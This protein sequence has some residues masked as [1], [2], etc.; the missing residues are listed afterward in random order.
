MI[1]M[2]V[3]GALPFAVMGFSERRIANSTWSGEE[4]HEMGYVIGRW[5][6]Q[7]HI[8]AKIKL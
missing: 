2:C 5:L 7:T 3:L 4:W 6:G 8:S 1:W